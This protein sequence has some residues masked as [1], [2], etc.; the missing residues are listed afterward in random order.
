M[1]K[2]TKC[3]LPFNEHIVLFNFFYFLWN[4][5]CWA[6]KRNTT[7]QKHIQVTLRA[8][9]SAQQLFSCRDNLEM[10]NGA[11]RWLFV[12]QLPQAG[13]ATTAATVVTRH[14]IEAQQLLF[15]RWNRHCFSS[16][17]TH[18][19]LWLMFVQLFLSSVGI[20][21]N[22]LC[23]RVAVQADDA[24]GAATHRWPWRSRWR[25]WRFWQTSPWTVSCCRLRM[26]VHPAQ[27]KN[28]TAWKQRSHGSRWQKRRRLFDRLV[29]E[30]R[31]RQVDW[32]PTWKSSALLLARSALFPARAITMLGLA[33]LWSSFTQFFA[34]TND[35]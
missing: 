29:S 25:S 15:K 2:G 3:V 7:T 11:W 35:S 33:C 4:L 16:T 19:R 6:T 23:A 24:G 31:C 1:I 32:T 12:S 14:V 27:E 9:A 34:R 20:N 30:R 17:M 5:K 18:F 28:K 10:T 26:T 13:W 8:D 21:I 22:T